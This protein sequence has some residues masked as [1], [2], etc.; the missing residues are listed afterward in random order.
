MFQPDNRLRFPLSAVLSQLNQNP[1]P[2]LHYQKV[3]L[4]LRKSHICFYRY[5]LQFRFIFQCFEFWFW[6]FDPSFKTDGRKLYFYE[7]LFIT[8]YFVPWITLLLK[9]EKRCTNANLKYA[10]FWYVRIFDKENT[11]YKLHG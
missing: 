2:Q 11:K 8:L 10:S 9:F 6:V 3:F 5:F 4:S 1:S 7:F